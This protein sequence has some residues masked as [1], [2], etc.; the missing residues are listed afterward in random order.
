MASDNACNLNTLCI[1]LFL[2]LTLNF[3]GSYGNV[4]ARSEVMLIS[5]LVH[6]CFVLSAEARAR[7][8]YY[9][10]DHLSS[11][12]PDANS[13]VRIFSLEQTGVA[14]MQITTTTRV[15]AIIWNTRQKL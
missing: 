13:I 4:K 6:L 3:K 14:F 11:R 5:F 1:F 7:L 2:T 12:K 8:Q 15:G 9:I 10:S